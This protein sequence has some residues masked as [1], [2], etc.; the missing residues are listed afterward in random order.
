MKITILAV[1]KIKGAVAPAV[2]EFTRRASRYWKLEVVELSE[3]QGGGREEVMAAEGRRILE[4]VGSD[5][6]LWALT[7]KGTGITSR[8]LASVLESLAVGAH[9]GIAFVIG[10]A[11]GLDSAVLAK[12]DRKLSLSPMTLPHDMARLFLLE[13]LYRAGTI[14]RNE[15]YHKGS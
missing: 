6:R 1:G 15:P 13:Q 14:R 7:R 4:H 9:P 8:G 3:G 12:A 11:H 2:Q 5:Q 10:G